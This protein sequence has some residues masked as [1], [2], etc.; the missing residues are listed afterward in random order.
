LVHL[1][2]NNNIQ[3]NKRSTHI[4]CTIIIQS[5]LKK[6]TLMVHKYIGST[7]NYIHYIFIDV[8]LV[9]NNM[10]LIN[11]IHKFKSFVDSS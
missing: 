11:Y 1:N 3:T 6:T 9:L 10:N 8:H 2:K 7:N 4:F 5:I